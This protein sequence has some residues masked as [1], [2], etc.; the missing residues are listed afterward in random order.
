MT[1]NGDMNMRDYDFSFDPEDSAALRPFH[2]A[3]AEPPSA[4]ELAGFEAILPAFRTTLQSPIRPISPPARDRGRLRLAKTSV[5]ASLAVAAA[6]VFPAS[7][8]AAAYTSKLPEP[9]QRW[10]HAALHTIG[11]PAPHHSNRKTP[12][13]RR[14]HGPSVA[15]MN[16]DPQTVKGDG[17]SGRE[18]QLHHHGCRG[19]IS[20]PT[21]RRLLPVAEYNKLVPPGATHLYLCAPIGPPPASAPSPRSSPGQRTAAPQ[22]TTS[23]KPNRPSQN[24]PQPSADGSST[25]QPTPSISPRSSP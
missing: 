12:A 15:D 18:F 19:P 21:L 22:P 6:I 14:E 20:A 7:A 8:V 5:P 3:L 11:V 9:V 17:R 16:N 1:E 25:S 24:S 23:S 10:A 4:A 2:D 13:A